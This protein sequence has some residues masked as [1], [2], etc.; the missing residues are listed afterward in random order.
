MKTFTIC[1][2][3][4]SP[5]G[6]SD[7]H[8]SKLLR[9]TQEQKMDSKAKPLT[10][11]TSTPAS[12][13]NP[14][15]KPH[16]GGILRIANTGVL[17]PKMGVPG[18]IYV[19]TPSLEPIV[20]HF[21]RVDKTGRM[22]PHLI[23][24]WE[25]SPDG[26]Q[27]TLNVRKGIKFHDGTEFNAQAA[28]WNLIKAR[29]TNGTLQLLSSADVITEYQ[30]LLN[31]KSYDNHFL[32]TLAY[33]PGFV[34]SPAAYETYGE[35]YCMVHPVG[36]GPFKF[37]SYEPDV[38]IVAARF[39]NYWQKGK[40]YLDG[41]E[42][43]YANE[44]K[45][46]VNMLK[47]GKVDV[48]VNI[49]GESAAE[50]KAGG[51]VVKALPW[52]MEGLLPD[53]L[54]AD[55]VLADKRVRQAIEYAIDRPAIVKTLGHGYW[56]PLTQLA[57]EAV[58]GYDP[59]VEGRPYNPAKARQLLAEAGYPNGFRI[60]LIGGEGT[61]L[62]KVF[63]MVQTYLAEVGIKAEIEIADP[64][65]WKQYRAD[66][67]WHNAMLFRHFSSDPNFT[68]SLFDFHSNREYGQT[69]VLRNF[70]NLLDESLRARDYET[71]VKT[72]RK[73]VKHIYDEA[74]VIPLMLDSSIAALSGR[75]HG[76]GYF[77]VHATKWTPWDAWIEQ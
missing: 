64:A 29:E 62:L 11:F 35:E 2:D 16:Y 42:M 68:W 61:E 19:G 77:E 39:D 10:T 8:L 14:S 65:L 69:S 20:E 45:T 40:P 43:L 1:D 55:S 33:S 7:S 59:S 72:T 46:A 32:P 53:S 38:K 47:G 15:M 57:T 70:D 5:L 36:T 12:A 67:P 18:R 3:H 4:P 27:L 52:N 23:E 30:L 54:N 66:K 24:E 26:L 73:V 25:Y 31:M 49:N 75:V 51:Y 17:P 21:L 44:M 41:I 60:K 76:L 6:K 28:K 48:V 56:H 63:T 50:L 58:Y 37:V 34:L 13:I 9:K 22:I 74:I 71:L